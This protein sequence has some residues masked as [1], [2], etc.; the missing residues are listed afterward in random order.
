MQLSVPTP[1][2][3][4][5]CLSV[6][7]AFVIHF[8]LPQPGQPFQMTRDLLMP[9]HFVFCLQSRNRVY[10]ILLLSDFLALPLMWKEKK[11]NVKSQKLAPTLAAQSQQLVKYTTERR[12]S[13]YFEP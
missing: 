4:H 13:S 6:P 9:R 5:V 2:R 11:K 1:S 8:N 10:K 7:V 3:M 12:L